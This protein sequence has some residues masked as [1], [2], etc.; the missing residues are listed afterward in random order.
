MKPWRK[1]LEAPAANRGVARAALDG[2]TRLEIAAEAL[3][4]LRA[5]ES[6]DRIAI[7]LANDAAEHPAST[8]SSAATTSGET[9]PSN[10]PVE[11]PWRGVVWDRESE[12]TP[13]EWEHLSSEA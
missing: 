10:T 12:S 5:E 6:A 9:H 11:A 2:A 1:K 8:M 4:E 13:A 3:R 7:W